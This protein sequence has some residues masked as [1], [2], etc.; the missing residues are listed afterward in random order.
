MP[1]DTLLLSF[2][3][4][5]HKCCSLFA[6]DVSSAAALLERFA[7]RA[8]DLRSRSILSLA[9]RRSEMQPCFQSF[10]HL[11]GRRYARLAEVIE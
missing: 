7:L 3:P 4:P 8:V 6:K 5:E 2:R 10:D 1:V 11:S 9:P